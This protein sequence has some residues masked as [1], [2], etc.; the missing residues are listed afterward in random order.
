MERLFSIGDLRG[1]IQEAAEEFQ[2]VLGD[3]VEKE[4]KKNNKEAYKDIMDAT[5]KYDGGVKNESNKKP[6][7]P[8]TDNLGMH[9]LE[10]EN[11]NP[12]FQK[13]VKAQ[14]KGYVSAEAEKL[15]KNDEFGNAEFHEIEGM[16]DHEKEHAKNKAK[17]KQIG[18]TS[19]EIDPK[20]FE[21]QKH[22]VYENNKLYQIK[23][24]HTEFI[25][26]NHML[27][28]VPD[29]FKVNG[30]KFIMKDMKNKEYIVEWADEPKVTCTTKINEQKQRIKELFAYQRPNSSTS[31][32]SRMNENKQ[33]NDML[34]KARRLM[35]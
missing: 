22:S 27:S 14:M 13:R 19:R 18:L 20:E 11:M 30:R 29:D 3:N 6:Q 28:K 23:F 1:M 33:I 5:K 16:E 21:N 24:K 8:H 17:A 32:A 7:Y 9:N 25:T 2:P 10:Y 34:G 15:H 35:K 26:E 31:N 4:N 12:E